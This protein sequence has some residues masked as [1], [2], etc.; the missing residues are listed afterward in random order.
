MG[1]LEKRKPSEPCR[2]P[3]SDR[4]ASRIVI[5]PTTSRRIGFHVTQIEAQIKSKLVYFEPLTAETRLRYQA[6]PCGTCDGQG[7]I[8]RSLSPNYFRLCLVSIIPSMPH[9]TDD[10][11]SYQLTLW[12]N[13]TP[14]SRVLSSVLPSLLWVDCIK[15]EYVRTVWSLLSLTHTHT[16]THIWFT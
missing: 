5:I 4:L 8:E 11:L 10:T 2:K 16:Q 14:L 13:K 9:T 12:S 1:D 3:N 15:Y 6:S 7:D